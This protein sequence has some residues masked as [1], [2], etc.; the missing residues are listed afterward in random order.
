MWLWL[1]NLQHSPP[2]L[3]LIKHGL[4][5]VQWKW[6]AITTEKPSL[7]LAVMSTVF[8]WRQLRN[9]VYVRHKGSMESLVWNFSEKSPDTGNGVSVYN[10]LGGDK[11]VLKNVLLIFDLICSLPSTSVRNESSFSHMKLVKTSTRGHLS[12]LNLGHHLMV[13]LG[14][15]NM[16]D[17]DP[18]TAIGHFLC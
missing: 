3:P 9:K 16:S 7:Q 1:Q 11:E 13:R 6:S 17:F 18:K 5:K 10:L 14:I 12:N 15:P 8:C 2:G 4:V